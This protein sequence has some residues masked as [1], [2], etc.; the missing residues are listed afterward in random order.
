MSA[1]R[2][3]E[4]TAVLISALIV[5]GGLP[6][7]RAG[8]LDECAARVAVQT[9][10]TR[11]LEAARRAA[12]DV[13]LESFV[14]AGRSL[15]SLEEATGRE[16]PLAALRLSQRDFERYLRSHCDLV[17]QSY[18][19]GG[20]AA[21]AQLACEADQFRDRERWLRALAP[22]PAAPPVPVAPAPRPVPKS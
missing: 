16:G 8:A 21:H 17:R 2:R 7:A 22:S 20:G 9:E 12:S 15:A 18:A 6:A 5:L 19:S 13:M 14:A 1:L 10:M 4:T 3:R 11:C